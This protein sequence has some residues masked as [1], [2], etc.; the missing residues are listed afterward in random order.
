MNLNVM[1]ISHMYP[2]P[3]NPMSGIFVHNQVKALAKEGVHL[4]VVSPIPHFPFYP[5]WR[6]YRK[7][8]T[9]A[10]MAEIPIWY[11]PTWMFPGGFFFSAYGYFYYSSLFR[12]VSELW[13]ASP[14]DLIHC[15]TIYPDGYAGTLLKKTFG[16]PVIT[17]IHGSDIRLYPYKSVGVYQRTEKALRNS[18]HVVTVSERLKRD[19]QKWSTGV[20]VSTIHNG[21]DPERFF[22]CAQQDARERLDQSP[23]GKIILFVGNLYK[24]KGL[25]DLLDAFAGLAQRHPDAQLVLVGDGPLRCDLIKRSREI[26]IHDRVHFIGRR[27]YDEIPLWINASDVVTLSSLSE[28]LPSIV[29]EAMG[30]GKP[31]VA[32][33]VG[34]I[35]EVVQHGKTG[36]LVPPRQ[37][38]E[39]EQH[40]EI[41][42]M[43][44]EGLNMDMGERAYTEAG[45]FTWK[46]NAE[47]MMDL[48][49]QMTGKAAC[50]QNDEFL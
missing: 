42:L 9:A 7:F 37:P 24:V 5:K 38:K 44:N 50:K 25:F 35:S 3:A 47:R 27:P 12:V 30:C 8:P 6:N 17:T 45:A 41:V 1:V 2:N 40:L 34:G 31:V 33:D 19:V 36:F 48:Y 23:D 46:R 15:H 39:L 4:R 13:K 29:L 43:D 10:T 22:P 49:L 20:E 26:S 28:G 16:V 18:D 32:T 14:F 21:F 11:V